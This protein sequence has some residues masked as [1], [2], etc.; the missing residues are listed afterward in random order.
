MTKAKAVSLLKKISIIGIII[1]FSSFL[2]FYWAMGHLSESMS[3]ACLECWFLEDVFMISIISAI[4]LAIIFAILPSGMNRIFKIGIQFLLLISI[5]F[6]W[7]YSIF[8]ERESSWS[9]FLFD[10]EIYYV[11]HYSALPILVL[12]SVAIFLNQTKII[13]SK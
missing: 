12:A 3:S 8:V 6:F 2:Q 4:F 7:D 5:W 10:E 9:T 11:L 13:D 1:F